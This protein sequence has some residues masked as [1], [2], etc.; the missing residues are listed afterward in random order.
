MGGKGPT[1]AKFCDIQTAGKYHKPCPKDIPNTTLFWEHSQ[2]QFH[3]MSQTTPKDLL[4]FSNPSH[5]M[6]QKPI[7]G[8]IWEGFG[9]F[10]FLRVCVCVLALPVHVYACVIVHVSTHD[11]A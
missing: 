5:T 7:L 8:H 4:H 1:N 10:L 2:I 11:L 6:S 9:M 3:I